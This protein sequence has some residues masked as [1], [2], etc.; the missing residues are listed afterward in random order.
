[1]IAEGHEHATA[2]KIFNVDTM[3]RR[4]ILLVA[5]NVE[6]AIRYVFG[7]RTKPPSSSPRTP[8]TLAHHITYD[9]ISWLHYPPSW[10]FFSCWNFRRVPTFSDV[11]TAGQGHFEGGMGRPYRCS[12]SVSGNFVIASNGTWRPWRI[13]LLLPVDVKAPRAFY[14]RW[15]YAPVNVKRRGFQVGDHDFHEHN[16]ILSLSLGWSK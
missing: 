8:S 10:Q 7:T 4:T 11:L 5:Y 3:W 16:F 12:A 15:D 6:F 9:T 14:C 13:D 1:M 2:V